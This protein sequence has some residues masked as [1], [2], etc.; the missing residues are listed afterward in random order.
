MIEYQINNVCR[1]VGDQQILQNINLKLTGGLTFI[2]GVSGAGKSTLLN[3]LGLLDNPDNGTLIYNGSTMTGLAEQ[4]QDQFRA[5]QIGFIF[6]DD[7]LL[8][9][10]TV[11]QNLDLALEISCHSPN[12]RKE[13][14]D[15]FGI[16]SLRHRIVNTLSGGERQRVAVAR[17]LLKNSAVILADEPTGSLDGQNSE[18]ITQA[19]RVCADQQN[20]IIVVVTH[21]AELAER[22]ADRIIT[23]RDGRIVDDRQFVSDKIAKTVSIRSEITW[24]TTNCRIHSKHLIKLAHLNLRRKKAAVIVLILLISF[25]LAAAG[26]VAEIQGST[27]RMINRLDTQYLETDFIEMHSPNKRPY[28]LAGSL[29][30]PFRPEQ[31]EYISGSGLFNNIVA[32]YGISLGAEWQEKNVPIDNLRFIN[33]D[34]FFTNRIMTNDIT[35]KFPESNDQIILGQ[36]IANTLF[37]SEDPLGQIIVLYAGNL[38]DDGYQVPVTVAGVNNT[39][40]PSGQCITYVSQQIS[41]AFAR[42]QSVPFAEFDR[43]ANIINSGNVYTGGSTG[44]FSSEQPTTLLWGREARGMA[45]VAVDLA[46]LEAIFQ[47]VYGDHLV[48]PDDLEKLRELLQEDFYLIRENAFLVKIVGYFNSS[49]QIM[50]SVS[51]ELAEQMKTP[52]P[53]IVNGYAR[54]LAV[55]RNFTKSDV[56][57]DFLCFLRYDHLRISISGPLGQFSTVLALISFLVLLISVFMVI[58]FVRFSITERTYEIGLLRALGGRRRDILNIFRLEQVLIGLAAGCA[59]MLV[60]LIFKFLSGHFLP[61]MAATSPVFGL[62]LPGV[63]LG[64]VALPILAG[65]IPLRRVYFLKPIDCIRRR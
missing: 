60:L 23:L 6:Q 11:E 30:T 47:N 63:F 62:I 9:D 58:S 65:L 8:N 64:S 13:I 45:E 48:L 46:V 7:N 33:L 59:A 5:S 42:S 43:A 56:A 21:N 37:G 34:S 1:M 61:D 18:L 32:Y 54:D 28:S 31:L 3:L 14:L 44:R 24:P 39:R 4:K 40:S 36:D 10:L 26:F 52:L 25:S 35:G 41:F 16:E 50:F 55:V 38:Q 19:L 2:L 17:A 53:T 49:G 29:G 20:R 51:E 27:A 57:K 12:N 15:Q 22:Y